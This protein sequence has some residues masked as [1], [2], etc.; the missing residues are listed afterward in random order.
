MTFS[1]TWKNVLMPLIS[2]GLSVTTTTHTVTGAASRRYDQSIRQ[3][4]ESGVH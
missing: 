2:P 4:N 1:I 3:V